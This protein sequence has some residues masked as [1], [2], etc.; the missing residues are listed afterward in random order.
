[1][2]PQSASDTAQVAATMP[3]SLCMQVY[4]PY[5]R[6]YTLPIPTTLKPSAVRTA[7]NVSYPDA[8]SGGLF[9]LAN[10][11]TDFGLRFSGE[12]PLIEYT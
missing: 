3:T 6:P 1:V 7:P 4:S 8:I 5:G 12:N 9:A 11:S 10:A 2:D